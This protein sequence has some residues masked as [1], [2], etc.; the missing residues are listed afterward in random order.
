MRVLSL[1]LFLCFFFNISSFP[2]SS[3][4]LSIVTYY[5]SSYGVY[6]IL[7]LYPTDDYT[8]GTACTNEGELVFDDSESRIMRCKDNGSG[9]FEWD[10]PSVCPDGYSQAVFNNT[11]SCIRTDTAITALCDQSSCSP[12]GTFR[13]TAYAKTTTSGIQTRVVGEYNSSAVC[14]SGWLVNTSADCSSSGADYHARSGS[15]GVRATLDLP[16][17]IT[18]S[19]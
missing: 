6:K 19:V 10:K 12:V 7:R 11:Y 18:C 17:G 15:F 4:K 5:P 2:A 3:D 1:F 9:G 13:S 14:D 16:A 8:P